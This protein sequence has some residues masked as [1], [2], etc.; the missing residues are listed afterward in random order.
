MK[1][2]MKKYLL[3]LILTITLVNIASAASENLKIITLKSGSTLKGKVLEL[4]DGIY[5]VETSDLGRMQIPEANIISILSPQTAGSQNSTS[6]GSNNSQKAQIKNQ[7]NQV[8]GQI[9]SDP[10]LMM[11]L[12]NIFADKE[13][14]NMLSDPKLLDDVLSYDPEKMQQNESVQDLMQNEKMQNLMEKILQTMPAQ[15]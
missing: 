1:D 15:E 8:Q 10:G 12:Q 7:V 3:T 6:G 9:L 5:T 14:Q 4:T 11:D 13:V 2:P